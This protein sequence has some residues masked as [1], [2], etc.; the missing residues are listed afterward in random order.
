[1]HKWYHD[2]VV[3]L[4]Q[5]D[6]T[7]PIYVSD[8]ANFEAALEFAAPLS[9]HDARRNPIVIDTQRFYCFPDDDDQV[10]QVEGPPQ[11]SLPVMADADDA[12]QADPEPA[13]EESRVNSEIIPRVAADANALRKAHKEATEQGCVDFI[14]GEYSCCI[15]S[16]ASM[17][18]EPT[19]EHEEA[20][21]ELG[22]AQSSHW[23]AIA[24]G[25]YFWTAKMEWMPG[26][27]WGFT[28][29]TDRGAIQA[30]AYMHWQFGIIRTKNA[31]ALAEM[32]GLRAE[33]LLEHIS[34]CENAA[35]TKTSVEDMN[36]Y[37]DGWTKGFLDASEFFMGRIE[38]NAQGTA[39]F[40]ADRIGFLSL[41]CVLDW[42]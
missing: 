6:A 9:L 14:I 34:H 23:Q 28:C 2:V 3:A 36:S 30:P 27:E 32:K 17:R 11:I 39:E 20:V 8:A 38:G 26:S 4:S 24:G 7:I 41:W 12:L 5:I 16:K 33:S 10:D 1:M 19:P 25:S 15:D 21:L 29:M 13:T 18:P 22:Q 40:G 31:I 37:E 42:P 35:G